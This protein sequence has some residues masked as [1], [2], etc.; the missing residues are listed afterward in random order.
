MRYLIDHTV[1]FAKPFSWFH[2]VIILVAVALIV[3]WQRK[4]KKLK[5]Q[6]KE[7]ENRL[8]NLDAD[9]AVLDNP[10]ALGGK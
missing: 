10:E 6:R 1:L 5:D 4:V 3:Y 7:L 8:V 2:L 9:E